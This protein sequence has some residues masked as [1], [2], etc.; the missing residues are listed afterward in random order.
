MRSP[1]NSWTLRREST[2]DSASEPIRQVL[3][4]WRSVLATF[5]SQASISASLA[6]R[7]GVSTPRFCKVTRQLARHFKHLANAVDHFGDV[8]PVGQFVEAGRGLGLGI[9]RL[10]RDPAAAVALT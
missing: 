9:G 5:L 1:S 3:V 6:F 7:S 10:E 4:G 8:A 2:T